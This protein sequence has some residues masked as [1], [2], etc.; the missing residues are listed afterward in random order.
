MFSVGI[1]HV[2]QEHLVE[3]GHALGLD[4]WSHV[5]AGA[6]HVDDEEA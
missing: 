6:R 3:V 5:D 2:G 4:Q 1:S